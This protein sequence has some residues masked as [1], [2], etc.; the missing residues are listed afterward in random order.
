MFLYKCFDHFTDLWEVLE[1]IS[2]TTNRS[3]RFTG[4]Y[5]QCRKC[6]VDATVD[7]DGTPTHI[8]EPY[9]V[10]DK[11]INRLFGYL[12]HRCCVCHSTDIITGSK[13]AAFY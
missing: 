13:E 2:L 3:I 5:K 9:N 1:Y 8:D 10:V 6:F 11:I 12:Y 4:C 7:V